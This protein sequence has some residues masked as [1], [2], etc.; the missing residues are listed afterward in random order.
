MLWSM[1]FNGSATYG[2]E[3]RIC[4]NW[5]PDHEDKETACSLSNLKDHCLGNLDVEC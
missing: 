3:I 1:V 4:R 5:Y 2:S